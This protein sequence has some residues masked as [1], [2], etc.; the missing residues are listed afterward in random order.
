MKKNVKRGLAGVIG[1]VAGSIG[2]FHGYNEILQGNVAPNGILIKACPGITAMGEGP[3]MTI[4]PNFFATGIVAVLLSLM[5]L[6]WATMFIEKKNG[7]LIL[8]ILSILLLLAGGGFLPPV[9]GIIAGGIY[10]RNKQTA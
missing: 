6:I 2:A 9:L 4:V 3:A 7:G 8:I 5:V 10:I 1:I